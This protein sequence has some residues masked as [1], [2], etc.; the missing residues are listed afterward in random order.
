MSR[1]ST[2]GSIEDDLALLWRDAGREGPVARA[3]MANLIVY[4][5]RPADEHVDLDAAIEDAP[6]D[7]IACRHPSRL[8]LLHHCAGRHPRGPLAATI[9]ILLYGPPQMRVGVEAIAIRV[10]C[11]DESLPS[12]VRRLARGDDDVLSIVFSA[13]DRDE[14]EASMNGHRVLVR[15]KTRVAPF[16]LAVPHETEAD[17]VAAELRTLTADVALRDTLVALARRFERQ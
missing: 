14:V 12:I 10:A 3:L 2:P 5:G 1:T 8:I 13:G 15:Y 7:E 16:S 17:A 6:V 4:R 9:G 11:A